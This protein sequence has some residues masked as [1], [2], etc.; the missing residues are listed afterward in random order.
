[1]PLNLPT[2]WFCR[3]AAFLELGGVAGGYGWAFGRGEMLNLGIAG[4]MD[5]EPR[6]SPGGP[7]AGVSKPFPAAWG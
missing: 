4:L 2:A 3:E 6:V 7:Y 5:R 1:M